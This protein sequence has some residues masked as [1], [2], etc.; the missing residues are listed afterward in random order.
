MMK[1]VK[2]AAVVLISLTVIAAFASCSGK[3]GGSSG[4]GSVEVRDLGG[5][6]IVIGNWWA[7]WDVETRTANSTEEEKQIEWRRKIQQDGNFKMSEKNISSFNEMSQLASTSI[8]SG[9]PAA[10]A[11][12]LMPGWALA[13]YNQGLVYPVS[14]SKAVDFSS[15]T[16]VMWN[17][18]T[19]DAFTF[20]GKSYAFN[21]GYGEALHASVI[22][23]N[24]RLFEEAGMDPETPYDMQKAGTW[25]WD[26]FLDICKKLTR[27]INND[28]I[29]DTYALVTLHTEVLDAAVGS[30]NANYVGK[31]ATGKFI[32]TTGTPNFLEALQYA[33]RLNN[34]G[35]VM[36]QA[37]GSNWDWFKAA[38][39]DGRGAMRVDQEYVAQELRDMSDDWGMVLFPRGPRASDWIV[40]QDENVLVIPST[41]SAED[42]DKILYA[43]SLWQTPVNPNPDAW[44]DGRYNLFRDSRAVD[45]TS[46]LIRDPKYGATKFVNFIPG[47]N[48][49]DI[50]WYMWN[51]GQDPAQ[52]IESVSQSWDYTIGQANN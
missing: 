21:T 25:T 27:D 31:D 50:G 1:R 46:A 2:Q 41:T 34:E 19:M 39:H 22:Y 40:V 45:E 36:P 4:S 18:G 52:L 44:K 12:V 8:I 11:F 49:G 17:K 48:K 7:D 13:L 38:F 47:L 26:A 51:E 42:V 43:Y 10:S 30:N 23:Y 14:D 15:T 16:P 37:A 35:V 24:K 9:T 20:G 32:N 29:V 6:E 33:V 28:G 3:K 5:I